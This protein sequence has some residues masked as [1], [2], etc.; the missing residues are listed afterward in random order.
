[1]QNKN[2]KYDYDVYTEGEGSAAKII[3]NVG[4]GKSVL[5]IGAG[6][7]SIT[8]ILSAEKDCEVSALDID[9][10]SIATLKSHC[11]NV[12]KADLNSDT[13][14][15]EFDSVDLFD[16]VIAADVLEHIYNPLETLRGLKKLIKRDGF[17]LL[18]IPHVA[19]ASILACLVD[20]DFAYS[21][22]GLLDKTH[23]RFFGIKNMQALIEDSGLKISAAEFVLK[24]PE[25]T[26]FHKKW[27]KLTSNERE[28]FSK[29]KFSNVYQV[30]IKAVSQDSS[31]SEV[32]LKTLTLDEPKIHLQ[33]RLIRI[34][35]KFLS[36]KT[37]LKIK[38][39]LN[40]KSR[41]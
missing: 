20:E 31:D 32:S 1:M 35:R 11:K 40:I 23:I 41:Y 22:R 27:A 18:S 14:I 30:V 36:E 38:A 5:E 29:H 28:L 4:V 3:R 12:F 37:L 26:E 6:F 19:H 8:K 39:F 25:D 33:Q 17:I 9:D 16:V 2:I 13:W 21:E 15:N 24:K 7:G 34:A 10:K